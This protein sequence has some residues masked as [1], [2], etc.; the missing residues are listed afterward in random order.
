MQ[1]KDIIFFDDI[2]VLCSRTVRWVYRYDRKQRFCFA[3]VDSDQ[4]RET[5]ATQSG[6]DQDIDSIVLKTGD[7]IYYRSDAVMQIVKKLQFPVSL[8]FVFAI[9]PRS[10]RNGVYDWIARNRY[11]WFGKRSSCFVPDTK[12]KERVLQ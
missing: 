8:L 5:L 2:C 10:L 6:H 4:Y 9:V 3:A 12:M 1:E 11:R 7:R